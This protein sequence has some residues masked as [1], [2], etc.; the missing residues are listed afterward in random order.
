VR[1]LFGQGVHEHFDELPV[2]VKTEAARIIDLLASFPLMYP[3]RRRGIMRGYRYFTS[4][5]YLF[6]Y[7]VTSTDV[8][9]AA[10]IP[11]VM[12]RA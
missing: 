3:V 10:I 1:I 12:A 2:P 4:F 6:F 11:G 5:R 9:V 7:S 8:R